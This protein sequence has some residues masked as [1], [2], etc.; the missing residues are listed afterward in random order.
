[1]KIKNCIDFTDCCSDEQKQARRLFQSEGGSRGL[2]KNYTVKK[3]G[4]LI[5]L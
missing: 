1:M 3:F 4:A 5:Q 2:L